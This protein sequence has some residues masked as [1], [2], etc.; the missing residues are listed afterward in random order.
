MNN[1]DKL[2]ADFFKKKNENMCKHLILI[3]GSCCQGCVKIVARSATKQIPLPRQAVEERAVA[4]GPWGVMLSQHSERYWKN[5]LGQTP[6]WPS[7]QNAFYLTSF[8]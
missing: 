7:V 1:A 3:R 2:I 4:R 8:L 6:S 5:R